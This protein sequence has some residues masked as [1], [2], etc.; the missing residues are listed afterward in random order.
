MRRGDLLLSLFS[1]LDFGD[2]LLLLLL[3]PLAFG[4]LLLLLLMSPLVLG[5]LLLFFSPDRPD[6]RAGDTLERLLPLVG[7]GDRLLFKSRCF[8][9]LLFFF[10]LD[11]AV[12]TFLLDFE[13]SIVICDGGLYVTF[14]LFG[15]FLADIGGSNKSGFGAPALITR[16]ALTVGGVG[17]A[18]RIFIDDLDL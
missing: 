8:D 15:L 18:T 14:R 16:R 5:D 17:G 6:V 11:L 9:S 3:S 12:L 7:A 13:E 10:S 4:D 1:P 2:L